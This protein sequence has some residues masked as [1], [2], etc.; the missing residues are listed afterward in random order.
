MEMERLLSRLLS[1]LYPKVTVQFNINFVKPFHQ[2]RHIQWKGEQ[3]FFSFFFLKRI[4]EYY[5]VTD[6]T[7]LSTHVQIFENVRIYA[8]F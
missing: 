1:A 6:H 7:D 4:Y 3:I 8:D 2:T 5:S